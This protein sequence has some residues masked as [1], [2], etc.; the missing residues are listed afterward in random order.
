MFRN[1][2]SGE[3][4]DEKVSEEH[5]DEL[6]QLALAQY[7]RE[8]ERN[9]LGTPI[10]FVKTRTGEMVDRRAFIGHEDEL[11]RLDK[12]NKLQQERYGPGTWRY[13]V[14]NVCIWSILILFVVS[15]GAGIW[16]LI[17]VL[18]YGVSWRTLFQ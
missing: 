15:A 17:K 16:Q 8:Q 3:T 14:V 13:F 7:K 9:G 10:Y 18:F 6:Y 12:W 4:V 5:D 1:A 2:R 11:Y